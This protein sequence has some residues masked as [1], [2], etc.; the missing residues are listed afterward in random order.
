MFIECCT[1]LNSHTELEES[2][3]SQTPMKDDSS[4]NVCP[5]RP[6]SENGDSKLEEQKN[7]TSSTVDINPVG[8]TEV[9]TGIVEVEYIESENLNDVED[10]DFTRQ[11]YLLVK[12]YMREKLFV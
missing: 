12:F 3:R 10:L 5:T 4:C 8:K 6:G 1:R 9:E 11:V 2:Y 7:N